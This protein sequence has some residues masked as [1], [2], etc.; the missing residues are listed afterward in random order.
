MNGIL[1]FRPTAIL[2]LSLFIASTLVLA[3]DYPQAQISNGQITVKMYLPD[4]QNGYY[5]STRFDW[6]GAVSSVQYKGHEYYGTWFDRI[7]P[8]VIN[9]VHQGPEI[10]SGPCSGLFGPV[11]EFETPLGFNE[12]Q[13]G[14][15][16]IKIGVGVLRKA[17]GGYNR[18]QPYEVLDSG[19]RAIKKASD[20]VE[21]TQELNDPATGYAYVYR[22]TVRLEKASRRWR[23]NTA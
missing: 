17:E 19:K 5:R 18:Y 12:A 23:S 1:S 22:K 2:L 10:V 6:S 3:A 7:D 15:T 11:D 13:P 9:W 14:G 21:F 20:S 4:A 16:F 8:K